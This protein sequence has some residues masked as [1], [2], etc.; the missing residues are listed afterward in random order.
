MAQA[1]FSETD[2][3]GA[4]F[5]RAFARNS[6]FHRAKIDQ[7]N[8]K[9]TD[10]MDANFLLAKMTNSDAMEANFFNADLMKAEIQDTSFEN[11]NIARTRLEGF[12]FP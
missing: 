9:G 10:L 8:F 3:F 6:R 5:E 2:L 1:D 11:A 7:V 4:S 12:R